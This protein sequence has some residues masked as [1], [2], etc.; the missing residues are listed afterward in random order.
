MMGRR[1]SGGDDRLAEESYACQN[2]L[3]NAWETIATA[4]RGY[5]GE[6]EGAAFDERNV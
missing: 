3:A 1:L 4:L 5:I 2:C 6:V